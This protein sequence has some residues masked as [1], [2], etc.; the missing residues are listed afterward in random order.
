MRREELRR[1]RKETT[2]F[3]STG[4]NA[5]GCLAATTT[6]ITEWITQSHGWRNHVEILYNKR[7]VLDTHYSQITDESSDKWK[8]VQRHS[9][10]MKTNKQREI[11]R[12]HAPAAKVKHF[13]TQRGTRIK[14]CKLLLWTNMLSHLHFYVHRD[15][16]GSIVTSTTATY[17]R[18]HLKGKKSGYGCV[19]DEWVTSVETH[20]E[21]YYSQ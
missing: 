16:S 7:E 18:D 19:G 13:R 2:S 17:M 5:L 11:E 15:K 14:Q 21:H 20:R 12:K 9:G 6:P 4:R 1:R 3:F 10:N 8:Q